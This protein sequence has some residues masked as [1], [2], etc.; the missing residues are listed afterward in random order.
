[1]VLNNTHSMNRESSDVT[2]VGKIKQMSQWQELTWLGLILIAGLSLR[3]LFIRFFPTIPFSDFLSLLDFA[4]V[5]RND[6]LAKNAW[7]WRYFSPGLPLILSVVLRFVHESPET[8]GRWTT[9]LV[10]GLVPVL[11]YLF[12]KD[13]F[14]ART[15][16]IAAALL[17][18]WP[19]QILFSSILAQDNWII[20]PTVA[21]SVLAVRVLAI[22]KEGY[23]PIVAALLYALTSAIRQEMMIVLFPATITAIL[24]GERRNRLRNLLVGSLIISTIFI[25]LIL[26]RGLATGFY[27]FRTEHFGKAILGAYVPGAGMGWI[28]PIPYVEAT[29]PE[30]IKNGDPDS[31]L[32]QEGLRITWHEFVRRPRFHVIRIFG[33]TLTN[34]FEM[35]EQLVWWSLGEGMLPPRYQNN[36]SRLTKNLL[37]LLKFYPVMINML[38]A[39]SLFFVLSHRLLLKWITPILATIALKIGLHAVIVSQ[40]RYYLVVIALEILVI[41]VVW[42]SML[43]KENWRLSLRSVILGIVSILLLI[44]SMNYAKEYIKTHDIVLHS[45]YELSNYP[46]QIVSSQSGLRE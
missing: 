38:F 31:K 16:I 30:L 34:L 22:K 37:P 4:I 43:K 23:T 27:T 2:G 19:S 29:Y 20:F 46:D 21:I 35:D 18:L 42:D 5:F 33:S 32:A 15:R 41:S 10:T 45:Y 3:L 39:C 13:I 24:A 1:M 11:P 44:V 25:A 28:D 12:W 36:V 6:W 17:A 40:S 26:Q 9:A 14:S 7:Q 8:V